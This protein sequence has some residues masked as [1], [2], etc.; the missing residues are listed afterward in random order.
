MKRPPHPNIL[1]FEERMD[2][3]PVKEMC[4]FCDWE[5]EGTVA[6]GRTA[7]L[8]HRR[9]HHRARCKPRRLSRNLK[10]FHQPKLHKEQ[11]DE[12]MAERDKRAFL[13]GIDLSSES[14]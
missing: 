10:S 4:L 5:F 7:A 9:R 14:A 1:E 3:L 13:I 6:E 2:A 8:R 12:I 11:E